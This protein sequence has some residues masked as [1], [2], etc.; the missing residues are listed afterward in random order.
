MDIILYR[1][2][3]ERNLYLRIDLQNIGCLK[4]LYLPDNANTTNPLSIKKRCS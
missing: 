3:H 1:R 2:F 4:I